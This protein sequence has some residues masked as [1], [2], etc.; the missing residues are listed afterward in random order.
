MDGPEPPSSAVS[1]EFD[2]AQDQYKMVKQLGQGQGGQTI[3]A[4]TVASHASHKFVVIKHLYDPQ[5][6]LDALIQRL[7]TVGEHPQLPTLIDGWQT[8]AGQFLAFEFIAAPPIAQVD[9]PPWPPEQVQALLLSLLPVLEHI[10]SFRLIHGDIRPTNI[11]QASCQPPILIDLRITQRL[12]RRQQFLTATGGDAAY[13]APEQALGELVYASD[14]YSLGLVA[15]HL[16]TGLTPFDLYSV[17]DNRWIWPDLVTEPLPQHLGIVLHGLLERSL[18]RRYISAAQALAAL[19]K[20]SVA[21]LL[22]KARSFLR[23]QTSLPPLPAQTEVGALPA[24]RLEKSV[25]QL[26]WQLCY[27]FTTQG[28]TTALALQGRTL[29]LGTSSGAVFVCDLATDQEIY[30]LSGSS[31]RDRIAALAFHPY[32]PILFS[33]SSDGTVKLWDLTIGQLKHTLRQPGWQPTDLAIALPDLVVSDGTGHITVWDLEQLTLRHTFSQHQDWVSAIATHGDSLA[34]IS[35]DRTLRFW[36]LSAQGLLDTVPIS[37]GQALALHPNGRH[38]IVGSEQGQVEVW[39]VDNLAKPDQLCSMTDSI[40]ALALSPDARLLAVGTD[41]NV[42]RVY[43]G[44]SG[45]CVS[46]LTQGW[47]V[48]AIAFDGQMLISSSQDETVTIW[49]QQDDS[50]T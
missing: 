31:H 47:G 19:K 8:A 6:S 43:Q 3:L 27:Q 24:Q 28:I 37:S 26:Q 35:R 46:E 21:S 18:A 5:E 49:Q 7:Q 40:T 34:S 36:S 12:G 14:L 4:R 13:A 23:S 30:T 15:I 20:T 44:A 10:H 50:V 41:G 39:H 32:S 45:Q 42:L 48:V 17:A 22:G 9:P 29:A 38:I 33:A 1:R 25:T 16:L 11:R 2:Q